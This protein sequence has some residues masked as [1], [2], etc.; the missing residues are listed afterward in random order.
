MDFALMSA[1]Q[2]HQKETKILASQHG[3]FRPFD[4][5]LYS[6][7][8]DF[9][10]TGGQAIPLPDKLCTNNIEAISLL[11]KAGFPV[12]KIAKTEALRYFNLKDRYWIYKKPIP[13]DR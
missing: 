10:E 2:R 7:S 5:R 9:N 8:R 12:E 13:P 6:D 3:F 1:W 4:L 11:Q